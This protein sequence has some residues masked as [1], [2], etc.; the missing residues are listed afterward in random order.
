MVPLSGKVGKE[1]AACVLEKAMADCQRRSPTIV[2]VEIDSPGGYVQE[3]SGLL[4]TIRK[5]QKSMR[6]VFYVKNAISAAAVTTFASKEIYVKPSGVIGAALSYKLT[7]SGTP[8]NVDEKMQSIW[9]TTFRSAA[10]TGGHSPLLAEAMIDAKLELYLVTTGGK[11]VIQDQKPPGQTAPFK[12]KGKLLTMTA[13]EALSSGL[14]L[15]SPDDYA[16]LGK[17]L[18]FQK[19]TE[20]KCAAGTMMEYWACAV[21]KIDGDFKK[22]RDDFDDAMAQ[23]RTN[24]PTQ[25]SYVV[26]ATTKQFTPESQ[27]KWQ[28]RSGI[29]RVSLR[30]LRPPSRRRRPWQRSIRIFCTPHRSRC[31]I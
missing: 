3:V 23:A 7:P 20:M 15:G 17:L 30:R 8:V 6:I 9:R 28:E 2:V 14:S 16:E 27:R 22:I 11:K 1:I 31:W 18:G 10:E 5:Y 25:Y 29:A 24:D 13:G 26:Y 12:V 19:W 4:D 21:K